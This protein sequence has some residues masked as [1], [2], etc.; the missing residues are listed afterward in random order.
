MIRHWGKNGHNTE[1]FVDRG[2][3]E[4]VGVD[5]DYTPVVINDD[6]RTL[7]L[8]LLRKVP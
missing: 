8:L 1:F 4:A 6:T 3:Y 5:N 7:E 2:V